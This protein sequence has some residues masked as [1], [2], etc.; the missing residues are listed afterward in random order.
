VTILGIDNGRLVTGIVVDENVQT[1]TLQCAEERLVIPLSSIDEAPEG[2]PDRR[3]SKLSIMPEGQLDGL[4]PE[5][6]R[7]LIAY[8]ASPQQTLI[9]ADDHSV[10]SFF[11]GKDLE[12]WIGDHSVWSVERGEIVGRTVAGLKQNSF[13]SSELL[14]TDFRLIIDVRLEGNQGNSGIQVRSIREANGLMRG[15]QAD[16][17]LGW[18]GKL[19]EEHGRGLLESKSGGSLIRP[20]EWNTYEIVMRGD[21]IQTSLNGK[22]IV[23][24][25]DPQAAKRGVIGLQVHSGGPT[26]VRFRNLRLTLNP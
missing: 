22:M 20:G 4:S 14:L 7:D 8:L 10:L 13:L 1:L 16:I 6:V 25:T 9:E 23:D 18:W 26:H 2:G 3:L 15:Y 5:D 11:N 12:G 21:R 24:R 17:G 19:Y